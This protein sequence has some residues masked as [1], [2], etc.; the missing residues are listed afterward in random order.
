MVQTEVKGPGMGRERTRSQRRKAAESERARGIPP[1]GTWEDSR[2]LE[3]RS[4]KV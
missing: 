2:S 1:W 3:G 4:L